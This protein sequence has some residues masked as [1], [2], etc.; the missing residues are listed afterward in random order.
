VKDDPRVDDYT[1][2]VEVTVAENDQLAG[3][4]SVHLLEPYEGNDGCK[5]YWDTSIVVA[6]SGQLINGYGVFESTL[7]YLSINNYS[8]CE[9]V[10]PRLEG[11]GT[12]Y[13][14]IQMIGD[15]IT[16]T[17]Q[18]IPDDEEGKFLYDFTATKQ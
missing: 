4:V 18:Q 6:F 2:E 3:S 7:H 9:S 12:Q 10:T 8:N 11:S 14:T 16:G 17:A 5:G 15:T 1:S 13:I